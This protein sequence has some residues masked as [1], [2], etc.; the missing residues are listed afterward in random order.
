[1]NCTEAQSQLQDFLD[2]RLSPDRARE[3]QTHVSSCPACER[4]LDLYR[5]VFGA[6]AAEPEPVVQLADSIM[7]K[8]AAE[9]VARRPAP[10]TVWTAA[11]ACILVAIGTWLIV[12]P[13]SVVPNSW[14]VWTASVAAWSEGWQD[15]ASEAWAVAAQQTSEAWTAVGEATAQLPTAEQVASLTFPQIPMFAVIAACVI[16]L[17]VDVYYL[18][19]KPL[20]S[21]AR[22]LAF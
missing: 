7:A 5:H 17:T 9:P 19:K 13:Q 22:L 21:P 4:E 11:A 12:S 20:L 2:G 14:W 16:A 1:M 3:V 8:V 15:E 18:R 6:L 10:W